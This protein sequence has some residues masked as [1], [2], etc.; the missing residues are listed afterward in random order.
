MR[1]RYL[2]RVAHL[3]HQRHGVHA[4]VR[5]ARQR[6]VD[7]VHDIGFPGATTRCSNRATS[8]SRQILRTSPR[9]A[10]ARCTLRAPPRHLRYLA[11]RQHAHQFVAAV[12]P[13]GADGFDIIDPAR[14]ER[15]DRWHPLRRGGRGDGGD[16][17][18]QSN[19]HPASPSSDPLSRR[20]LNRS[21]RQSELG[22]R[23]GALASPT[24]AV[25]VCPRGASSH[26]SPTSLTFFD[27]KAAFHHARRDS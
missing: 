23:R 3:L 5:S 2:R 21:L 9:V 8:S 6:A 1:S 13:A 10:R 25:I 15:Q 19:P 14:R 20:C 26:P 16:Q 7:A 11:V 4:A 22:V 27:G 12:D 24:R 18:E 17:R